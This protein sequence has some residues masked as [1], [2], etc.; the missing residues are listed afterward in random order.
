M[1]NS[2]M[3]QLAAWGLALAGGASECYL[4][5]TQDTPSTNTIQRDNTS[6]LSLYAPDPKNHLD[7][8]ITHTTPNATYSLTS[9]I[10][11]YTWYDGRDK[12]SELGGYL[13][14]PSSI[15]EMTD[16]H[17]QFGRY[18]TGVNLRVMDSLTN[19][20]QDN[21]TRYT[22]TIYSDNCTQENICMGS[23]VTFDQHL[24]FYRCSGHFVIAGFLCTLDCEL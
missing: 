1:C 18:W 5:T 8:T 4:L 14:T 3:C 12:C 15:T 17:E 20:D 19:D 21:V 6:P 10:G 23:C 7:T 13:Y 11:P 24:G 2:Q 9:L 22:H 16:L